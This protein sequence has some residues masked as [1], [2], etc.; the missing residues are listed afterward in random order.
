MESIYILNTIFKYGAYSFQCISVNVR[1]AEVISSP[2][3]T[4]CNNVA[5]SHLHF[6]A[7]HSL[8]FQCSCCWS[9][10][11]SFSDVEFRWGCRQLLNIFCQFTPWF[12]HV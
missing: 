10:L 4:H 7:G 2:L 3:K 9:I 11:E 5:D 1:D 8:C 12:K 6:A